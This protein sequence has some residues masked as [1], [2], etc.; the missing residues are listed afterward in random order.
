MPKCRRR[1]GLTPCLIRA[2]SPG[3]HPANVPP[4]SQSPAVGLALETGSN[5]VPFTSQLPLRHARRAGP[6][7]C[8]DLPRA[9]AAGPGAL[10]QAFPGLPSPPACSALSLPVPTATAALID[11]SLLSQILGRPFWCT[12]S[13]QTELSQTQAARPALCHELSLVQSRPVK[14]RHCRLPNG[15]WPLARHRRDRQHRPR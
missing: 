13:Q 14:S 15:P 5:C 8:Q 1:T 3:T 11:P 6:E 2:W 9:Q 12:H 10:S 4:K 7:T